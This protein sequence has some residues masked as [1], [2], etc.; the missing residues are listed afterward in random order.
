MAQNT[1]TKRLET[2]EKQVAK[3][4][5]RISALDAQPNWRRAVG[6]FAGD[7]YMRKIFAEGR[8]IREADRTHARSIRRKKPIDAQ[9]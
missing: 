2:L 9:S 1:L 6:M 4:T 8:K 3:L 7:E 5:A